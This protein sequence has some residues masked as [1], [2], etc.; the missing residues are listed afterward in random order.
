MSKE[1]LKPKEQHKKIA[2]AIIGHYGNQPKQ[3][4][5]ALSIIKKQIQEQEG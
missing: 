2:A 4:L 5:L 3:L 1:K